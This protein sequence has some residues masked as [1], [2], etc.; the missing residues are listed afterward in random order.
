MALA[1]ICDPVNQVFIVGDEGGSI[2]ARQLL[3]KLSRNTHRAV[4][5]QSLVGKVESSQEN[6]RGVE[7]ATHLALDHVFGAI[8]VGEIFLHE[9]RELELGYVANSNHQ[10]LVLGNLESKNSLLLGQNKE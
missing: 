9:G 5:G 1:Q 8:D 2:I 4:G 6:S 3:E 10:V 7:R